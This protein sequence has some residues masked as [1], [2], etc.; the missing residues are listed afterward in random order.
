MNCYKYKLK[1]IDMNIIENNSV[2]FHPKPNRDD[3]KYN[4]KIKIDFNITQCPCF[5]C[6]YQKWTEETPGLHRQY[7]ITHDA[8]CI[9][10]RC[11]LNIIQSNILIDEA[12]NDELYFDCI[13]ICELTELKQHSIDDLK[14]VKSIYLEKNWNMRKDIMS[15]FDIYL[16]SES[17]ETHIEKYIFNTYILRDICSY[18]YFDENI[19]PCI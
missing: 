4:K 5:F 9:I 18:L 16:K 1:I 11:N 14:K 3:P 10:A 13:Y 19:Y 6:E 2:L 12:M 7:H 17:I 15:L 8:S